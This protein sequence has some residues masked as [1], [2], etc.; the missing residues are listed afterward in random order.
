MTADQGLLA[1]DGAFYADIAQHGYAGL[2]RAALRFFP[3]TP[4]AGRGIGWLG[5]GPRV[6]VVIVANIAALLAGVLLVRLVPARGSR[7]ARSQL[8]RPGCSRWHRRSFVLV[9]GYAEG[10]FITVAIGIFLCAR[11]RRWLM[12]APLGLLAG[13]SRPGGFVVA[14]P[15]VVEAWRGI[16]V[17]P[18]RER[19]ERVIGV[20]A[21]FVGTA[22]YLAWVDH[23]FGDGLLPFRVQTR[24]GLKGAFTNPVESIGHAFDGLVTGTRI[25]TGLHL[26]WMALVIVLI[27]VC[28][29]RLPASYG[30]YAIAMVASAVTSDNLD[31]FERYALSAF[32]ILIAAA[33]L[34]GRLRERDV[35]LERAVIAMS[36]LIM[37]G[38][39]TLAF[40]HEYVP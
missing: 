14:V 26:P 34:L 38:Y 16:T 33:L 27:V 25:G 35:R 40:L 1:W 4:L 31:S 32:P 28:F 11:D 8:A 18:W 7:S 10:L 15:I 22:L 6:G 21:P 29:R 23:R 3:L 30:W 5:V 20:V 9:L 19:A 17:A 36:G 24:P 39:A 12:C 13:L 37:T 2:P